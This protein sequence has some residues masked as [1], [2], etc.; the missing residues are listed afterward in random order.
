M[1]FG[2]A[3]KGTVW[4][5]KAVSSRQSCSSGSD[6]TG[7]ARKRVCHNTCSNFGGSKPRTVLQNRNLCQH[8]SPRSLQGIHQ[9]IIIGLCLGVNH[10][11][12]L[13]LGTSRVYGTD[14]PRHLLTRPGPGAHFGNTPLIDADNNNA[15]FR[16]RARIQGPAQCSQALF[17]RVQAWSQQQ[18]DCKR[19]TQHEQP[20]AP[21]QQTQDK[22]T[23]RKW[24]FIGR[25]GHDY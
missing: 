23:K 6:I 3:G 9:Q 21:G 4:R 14:Q 11:M 1:P 12:Q 2:N 22:G 13:Q 19:Q 18:T 15:L 20:A 25:L 5:Q 8:G 16:Y 24:I 10:I 17:Q 7:N